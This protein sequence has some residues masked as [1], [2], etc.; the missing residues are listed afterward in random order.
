MLKVVMQVKAASKHE[1]D[2]VQNE[3]G[4]YGSYI[5]NFSRVVVVRPRQILDSTP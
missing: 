2:A 4:R 1:I 5:Y 3:R